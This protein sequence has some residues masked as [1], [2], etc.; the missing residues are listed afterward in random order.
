MIGSIEDRKLEAQ[1]EALEFCH[2]EYINK[3]VRLTENRTVQEI[4]KGT[5]YDKP[6]THKYYNINDRV[7]AEKLKDSLK[8]MGA[9]KVSL[10]KDKYGISYEILF[11]IKTIKVYFK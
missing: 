8:T 4:K 1:L 9:T 10:K 2:R 3:G 6:K 7:L 11:N 5:G